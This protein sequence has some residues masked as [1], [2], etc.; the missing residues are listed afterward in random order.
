MRK[1]ASTTPMSSLPG[2]DEHTYTIIHIYVYVFV[3]MYTYMY[4]YIYISWG[5]EKLIILTER[6]SN[7][8]NEDL[9]QNVNDDD[10]VINRSSNEFQWWF[11]T[12]SCT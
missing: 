2:E 6:G 1:E 7:C 5:E 8:E 9:A 3:Y 10:E 11:L 4:I 12:R